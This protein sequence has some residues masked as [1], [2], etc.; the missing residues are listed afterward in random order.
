MGNVPVSHRL[1]HYVFRL[2]R[3]LAKLAACLAEGLMLEES[4]QTLDIAVGTARAQ[5]E[6]V[7]L[8]TQTNRQSEFVRLILKS[9]PWGR[10]WIV[11]L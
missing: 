6:Q 3:A 1:L 11:E 10:E 7:F 5:L 8:K 9:T 4:A 2:S